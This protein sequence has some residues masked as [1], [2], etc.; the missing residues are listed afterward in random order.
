MKRLLFVLSLVGVA[1]LSGNLTGF[2]AVTQDINQHP[3]GG[4][5]IEGRVHVTDTGSSLIIQATATGL[6]PAHGYFSLI[7][8]LGSHPG[9]ISQSQTLPLTGNAIAP[10]SAL[11][12][13]GM[14]TIT[15]AQMLGGFW[16]VHADG[17]GTLDVVKSRTGNSQEDFWPAPFVG[18]LEAAFGFVPHSNS[19]AAIGTWS[20]MSIR[21]ANLNFALQA[22]GEAQGTGSAGT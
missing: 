14:D 10:C 3:V 21:D 1:L 6:N 2:A 11:N 17:T 15:T 16:T 18:F 19:Y 12:Q 9:G 5:G 4:S 8:T 22:C 7:Y 13:N 20:T